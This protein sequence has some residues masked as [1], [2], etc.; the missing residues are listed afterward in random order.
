MVHVAGYINLL[1]GGHARCSKTTSDDHQLAHKDGAISAR[2][3]LLLLT[4]AGLAEIEANTQSSIDLKQSYSH[5][6]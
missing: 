5:T 2:T 3:L 6:E 1:A 4:Q